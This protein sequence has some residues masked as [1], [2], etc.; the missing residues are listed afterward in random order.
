MAGWKK[1]SRSRS[2]APSVCRA[3]SASGPPAARVGLD[4]S[5]Y[6][7]NTSDQANEY[8]RENP[9]DSRWR[10][11]SSSTRA[12]VSARRDSIHRSTGPGSSG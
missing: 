9:S 12:A 2:T 8:S 6:Q 4:I 3:A 5:R 7:S 10:S 11:K 1:A